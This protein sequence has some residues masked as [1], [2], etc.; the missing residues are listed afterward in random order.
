MTKTDTQPANIMIQMPDESVIS[1][2]LANKTVETQNDDPTAE[3]KIVKS[4]SLR[5]VYFAEG[6]NLMKLKVALSDWGVASINN[7]ELIGLIQP[8]V[9]RSPEVLIKAPWN[10]STDIWNLGAVVPELL[11]S[12]WMFIGRLGGNGTYREELHLEEMFNLFGPFPR[13]LLDRGDK[14]FVAKC[15]D[16]EGNILNR[17][18][19]TVGLEIRFAD[20]GDEMDDFIDFLRAMLTIDPEKRKTAK[21][22]SEMAWAIHD[23]KV[24]DDVEESQ[25]D[26]TVDE[27]EKEQEKGEQDVEKNDVNQEEGSH[28]GITSDTNPKEAD[29]SESLPNGG[30]LSEEEKA[31][32]SG[33]THADAVMVDVTDKEERK[34]IPL[35]GK[36]D[37][38]TE[39]HREKQENREAN[40]L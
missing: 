29:A 25:D 5:E 3:Y 37:G 2:F 39:T 38:D 21:Q 23:F 16:G 36:T 7:K 26:K 32:N 1:D 14:D 13:S 11:Y 27:N 17:V 12:Q 34:D 8:E 28:N 6:F 24:V 9:L 31:E 4:H 40:A 19:S 30:L 22:L 10:T 33:E 20:M 15:F 35:E 18:M